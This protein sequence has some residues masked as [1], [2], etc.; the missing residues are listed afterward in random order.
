[1]RTQTCAACAAPFPAKAVIDGRVR[2]L[3]RR[4]FCIACSPFGA[5]NTSRRPPGRISP[6]ERAED[7]RRRH[8]AITYRYQKTQRR[9]LKAALVAERG[10]RCEDC[11]Y[12]G[13]ASLLE[14]HHRDPAR[15]EFAV[16]RGSVSRERML[17]EAAKCDLLCANC[18]RRRHARART[19]LGHPLVRRR[20]D[21]KLRAVTAAGGACRGCGEAVPVALFDFHHRDPSTKEFA[22]GADG[23]L[24]S[25]ARVEAEL[26]KCVLLC[27]NCHREVHAGLRRLADPPTA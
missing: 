22:I 24:R 4:R 13:S 2:S 7:R 1:V 14:F 16:S 15:K 12:G 10:G 6:A 17:R 26:A 23:I 20:R 3:Y 11:G 9:G 18:H 27:A 21:T 19:A 5:H 25:W 8:N